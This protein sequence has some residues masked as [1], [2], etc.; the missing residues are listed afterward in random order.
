ALV[1]LHV[2]LF[3]QRSDAHA[4]RPDDTSRVDLCLLAVVFDGESVFLNTQHARVGVKLD[5]GFLQR[6]FDEG[7]Y[8]VAH[9]GH[10]V[11]AHLDDHH[12]RLATE[13]TSF[14]SIAQQVCHLRRK[15]N[16]ARTAADDS[17]GQ[18]ALSFFGRGVGWNVVERIGHTL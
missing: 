2:Q 13:R 11:L 1:L 14:E 9:A 7:A 10:D 8:L 15:L 4:S 16:T 6:L 5:A 12:T 3:N 17:E 18:S